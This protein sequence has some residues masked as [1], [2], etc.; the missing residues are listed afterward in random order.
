MW[1]AMKNNLLNSTQEGLQRVQNGKFALITESPVIKY[2]TSQ[3]CSLTAIG[4]QFSVRP[5]AFALKEKSLFTA[6]FTTA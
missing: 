2:F 4:D 6:K 1:D 5:Y 3:D